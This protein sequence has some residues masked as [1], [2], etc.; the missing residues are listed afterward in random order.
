MIIKP[1]TITDIETLQEVAKKSWEVTYQKILSPKQIQYMLKAFY[2]SEELENQILHQPNYHYYLLTDS[3]KAL[4]FVGYEHDYE[5]NT[6]KL[7]RIYLLPEAKGRGLGKLAIEFIQSKT[8]EHGNNRIILNVNKYNSAKE[9]Y[10]HLGFSVYDEGVFDIG[11]GYVMDD[12]LMELM[13]SP[14]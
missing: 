7:H 5:N 3:D 12:Y 10:Q 8:L 13:L 6:T 4:G 9:F 2:N 1:A 11:N 14:Q